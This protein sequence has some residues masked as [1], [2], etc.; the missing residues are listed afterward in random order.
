[1]DHIV[2]VA[3]SLLI[4][5]PPSEVEIE[6]RIR[7]QI[8]SRYATKMLISNL[9]VQWDILQYSEK[10]KISKH[11]R[12]C[13]YRQ[14]DHETICKSSIAK[15]DIN[16]AWC[17]L[18]VSIETPVPHLL[19]SLNYVNPVQV[20]R[21]R[22][23]LDGHY[24]DV[25]VD[26][27]DPR[28]EVEV[29]DARFFDLAALLSVVERVCA[30]LQGNHV[31][32]GFY[33]WKTVMHVASTNFGPFCIEK[34]QYQKPVTMTIDLLLRIAKDPQHW[35]VTPKV[36]GTR[37]F[38][39]SINKRLFSLGIAKDVAYEG[40]FGSDGITIM[41]CEFM[42]GQYYI[43]DIPVYMG[44]YY[45]N[46]SFEDRMST[47]EKTL[48]MLPNNV[49]ATI[50]PYE[51]FS[52]FDDLASLY[53]SFKIN[54]VIDGMVFARPDFGYLQTVTKWK[55]QSTVD[56]VIDKHGLLRTS[57][58]YRINMEYEMSSPDMGVWEFA[59]DGSKLIAKRPR[60]DKPQAN[61]RDIVFKNMFSSVP[62]T[63]FT[64]RG[65]YMMRK[66]HNSIKKQAI[67]GAND[68]NSVIMDIGTGQ[69]GD[70]NKWNRASHVY[71]IEPSKESISEMRRRC[72]KKTLDKI[73]V[74]ASRL[75]LIETKKI[76]KK[77][78]IFTAFFCMNQ[79]L[80][81]DWEM[82]E[83]VIKN[84]GSSKC[85]LLAI[86]MTDPREH[87][88]DNLDIKIMGP[89]EYEISIHGTRIMNTRERIVQPKT[90][91]RTGPQVWYEAGEKRKTK[92]RRFYDKGRK[93]TIVYV[94]FAGISQVNRSQK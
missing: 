86:V 68:M 22:A 65:F 33:D 62:G 67:Q 18:H 94:H 27:N 31:F 61:S 14:R 38:L 46:E 90:F 3:S 57:D 44:K 16:D 92:Q 50:K 13:T 8:T 84:N 34:K 23:T 63:L 11:N 91:C 88:S 41:D 25:V 70:V 73:T 79:W 59:Y 28:V 29:C 75:A 10:R 40:D 32:V 36:D 66:Y 4:A 85:R 77:V 64:G 12:K 20:T 53:E 83:N 43:F 89:E 17:T 45:G 35:V 21:Y 39:V 5:C 93:K 81:D 48:D 9:G 52:S 15:A 71:C 6:A 42:N 76:D 47:A 30:A 2:D 51:V 55:S 19:D 56:L 87:H 80:D 69:G 78:D 60:P 1:M 24:I 72:D 74:I 58:R 26:D 54:Y 82:L 49:E 37:R 7:K